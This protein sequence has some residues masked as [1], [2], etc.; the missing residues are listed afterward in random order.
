MAHYHLVCI[1]RRS[2]NQQLA[3]IMAMA[4]DDSLVAAVVDEPRLVEGKISEP[5]WEEPRRNH[6]DSGQDPE[7]II[8]A[9]TLERSGIRAFALRFRLH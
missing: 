6:V 2:N 4:G 7:I 9:R 8:R 3:R 5:G 1:N